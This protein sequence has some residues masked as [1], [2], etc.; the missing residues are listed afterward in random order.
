MDSWLVEKDDINITE[1]NLK[2]KVVDDFL[3]EALKMN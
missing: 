1:W 3:W 2:Y